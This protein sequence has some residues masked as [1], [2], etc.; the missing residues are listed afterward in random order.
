MLNNNEL[1]LYGWLVSIDEEES[2]YYN[3]VDCCYYS[4]S[5]KNGLNIC[6]YIQ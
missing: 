5:E 2:V 1:S 4:Y 6:C 3:P